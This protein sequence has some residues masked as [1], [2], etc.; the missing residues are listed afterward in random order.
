MKR[1]S[2]I[3]IFLYVIIFNIL[4]YLLNGLKISLPLSIFFP[5]FALTIGDRIII[6]T[7]RGKKIKNNPI[8]DSILNEIPYNDEIKIY[9]I[10]D[11]SINSL[12][13]LSSIALTEGLI[14]KLDRDE[15]KGVLAHEIYH[16]KNGDSKFL[17]LLAILVGFIP[18]LC[19]F[20]R[21]FTSFS[22][23]K[24]KKAKNERLAGGIFLPIIVTML[25]ILAPIF[26]FILKLI[27]PKRVDYSADRY[28]YN[29]TSSLISAINKALIDEEEFEIANRGIQYLYFIN[30]FDKK[31][32]EKRLK[33]L[34]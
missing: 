30:P 13:T 15:I 26:T 6:T 4:G 2:F 5:V 22:K 32:I 28:S 23:G 8:I 27:H 9:I 25:L 12:S 21:R 10:D 18:F 16:I 1:E 11:N 19:D 14:N 31:D 29:I 7:N 24:S 34:I 3:L 33:R 17:T 20:L